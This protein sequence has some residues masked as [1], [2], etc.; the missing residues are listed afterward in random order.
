VHQDCHIKIATSRYL[1]ST[2]LLGYFKVNFDVAIRLTYAVAA[3][4]FEDHF[5]K[6]MAVNTLKLPPIDALMGE[7]MQPYWHLDWLSQWAA[8]H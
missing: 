3:A 2:P 5:E 7:A 4:V 1:K 6:F 8:P